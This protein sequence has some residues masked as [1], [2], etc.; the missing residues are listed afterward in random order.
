MSPSLSIYDSTNCALVYSKNISYSFLTPSIR[1]FLSG[2]FDVI[3][4]QL[5]HSVSFPKGAI[6]S[7]AHL[8][9][10]HVVLMGASVKMKR[11]AACLIVAMMKNEFPIWNRSV[12]SQVS[13]SVCR[14][15]GTI[16]FEPSI[17][18]WGYEPSPSPTDAF[19]SYLNMA[20]EPELN[21]VYALHWN[22]VNERRVLCQVP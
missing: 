16:P 4:R 14:D 2:V 18:I 13:E 1:A 8:S 7:F 20:P 21:I 10:I 3:I 6:E 12:R 5:V 19:R 22:T 17:S 11:V 15:I 9:V